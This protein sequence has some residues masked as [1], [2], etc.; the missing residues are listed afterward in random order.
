MKHPHT[1]GERRAVREAWIARR[2][3][4]TRNI[5]REYDIP[6]HEG[7]PYWA[8]HCGYKPINYGIYAK[9]NLGCGSPMCHAAK[10]FSCKRQR[11]RALNSSWSQAEFRSRDNVVDW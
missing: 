10:Y 5:W 11:R 2:K 9:F 1:R 6:P 4:I 8:K 3:H 7:S